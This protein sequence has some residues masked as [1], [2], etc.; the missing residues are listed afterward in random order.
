M[1]READARRDAERSGQ[2]L[3]PGAL[4]PVADDHQTRG[5]QTRGD[6]T[7]GRSLRRGS[8]GAQQ[9]PK[10]LLRPQRR[11]GGNHRALARPRGGSGGIMGAGKPAK[12]DAVG[13]IMDTA[14]VQPPSPGGNPD[15]RLRGQRHRRP[16]QHQPAGKHAPADLGVAF[17]RPETVLDVDMADQRGAD[18]RRQVGHRP[19]DRT[20]VVGDQDVRALLT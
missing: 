3:Q 17:L 14:R 9:A 18:D 16:A 13:N 4:R 7:G 8:E 15:E 2:R 5:D 20:P 10:V 19:L 11:H 6:Q 1:A 12:I